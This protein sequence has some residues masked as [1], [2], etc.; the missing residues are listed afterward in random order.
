M[1]SSELQSMKPPIA[2]L[3]PQDLF[4]RS[5]LLTQL[6]CPSPYV[7]GSADRFRFPLSHFL[8]NQLLF[9]LLPFLS[10]VWEGKGLGIGEGFCPDLRFT[11][12]KILSQ[13]CDRNQARNHRHHQSLDQTR[14]GQKYL[15][16]LPGCKANDKYKN[17]TSSRHLS[18]RIHP[19]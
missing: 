14:S 18:G 9:H 3:I 7:G 6:L 5:S 4:C 1:L 8:F 10:H 2:Q 19:L 16:L 17:R 12:L 13:R 11:S 15:H